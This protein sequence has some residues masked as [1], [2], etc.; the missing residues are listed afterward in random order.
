M[1][2][3]LRANGILVDFV[4]IGQF[5]LDAA[6]FR[7]ETLAEVGLNSGKLGPGSTNFGRLR[8]SFA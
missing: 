8:S 4:L 5:W 7:D 1:L 3:E 2:V 6:N